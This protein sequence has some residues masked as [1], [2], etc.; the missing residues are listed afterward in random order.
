MRKL[1]YSLLLLL[2]LPSVSNGIEPSEI[3]NGFSVEDA[4]QI[5]QIVSTYPNIPSGILS[6]QS[7]SSNRI[8]VT[9]GTSVKFP[10]GVVGGG[11]AVLYLEK[12]EST[13]HVVDKRNVIS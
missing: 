12:K 4:K 5:I 11:G 6:I 3:N 2:C 13:W 7:V 8:E 10:S 1:G 9:L